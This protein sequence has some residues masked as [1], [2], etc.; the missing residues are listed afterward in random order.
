MRPAGFWVR[1]L[2]YVLDI[3]PIVAVVGAIAYYFLGFD[4]V[5][6]RYRSRAEGDMDVRW[7]YLTARNMIRNVSLGLYLA[8]CGLMEASALRGTL[9]KWLVGVQVVGT[10][11]ARLTY[12]Q[13]V[14]RNASKAVSFAAFGLGCLRVAWSADKRAW[15]DLWNDTVVRHADPA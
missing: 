10:D 1:V 6:R 3:I 9:G 5:W 14:R 12:A 15:H 13:S 8:Y 11:G 7:E 2:A 4:D